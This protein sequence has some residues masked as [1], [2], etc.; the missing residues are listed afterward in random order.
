VSKCIT[1]IQKKTTAR[2]S[3]LFLKNNHRKSMLLSMGLA[4]RRKRFLLN[5]Y[6]K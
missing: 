3:S 5:R 1:S 4:I 6:P 2:A